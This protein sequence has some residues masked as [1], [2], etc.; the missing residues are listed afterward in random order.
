MTINPLVEL[1]RHWTR[2]GVDALMRRNAA[3]AEIQ[4]LHERLAMERKNRDDA[5]AAICEAD[6]FIAWAARANTRMEESQ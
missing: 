4:R 3:I 5:Q 1:E 2:A 6:E